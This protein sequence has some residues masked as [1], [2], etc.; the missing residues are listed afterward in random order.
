MTS[1]D[2]TAFVSMGQFISLAIEF[3][4]RSAALYHDLKEKARREREIRRLA[5]ARIAYSW[6]AMLILLCLFTALVA[7]IS[8]EEPLS[9]MFLLL[10]CMEV[11]L[12]VLVCNA[13]NKIKAL[14]GLG[15]LWDRYAASRLASSETS[16]AGTV[17]PPDRTPADGDA[18]AREER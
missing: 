8:G 13:D 17:S 1:S 12:L 3:E 6:C 14:R 16:N 9:S 15:E 2:G 4:H 18:Q 10:F 11:M 7:E 5:A